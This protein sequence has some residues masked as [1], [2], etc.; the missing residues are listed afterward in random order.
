M[1]CVVDYMGGRG[2]RDWFALSLIL[3]EIQM[4]PTRVSVWRGA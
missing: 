2:A 3:K 1:Y 4:V